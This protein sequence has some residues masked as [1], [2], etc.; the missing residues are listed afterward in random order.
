[1]T[2][3]ELDTLI[4]GSGRRS[5]ASALI[6]FLLDSLDHGSDG[7]DL[8]EFEKQTGFI[9]T[10]IT[11]VAGYLQASNLICILYYRESESTGKRTFV[12]TNTY[13]RW[14][15]QHYRLTPVLK[16]LYRRNKLT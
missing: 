12:E 2:F 1:M 8:D 10:N 9:R 16:T 5:I 4:T 11:R 7:V 15:K 3:T 6:A 14:A 13:G